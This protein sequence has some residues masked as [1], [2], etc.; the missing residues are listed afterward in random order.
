MRVLLFPHLL[1]PPLDG[2]NGER[3]R[4]VIDAEIHPARIQREIVDPVRN[5]LPQF[6][7]RE[8]VDVHFRRFAF[9]VPFPPCIF[10]VPDEFF[11]LR[12]HGDHRVAVPRGTAAQL[13]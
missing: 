11:F 2:G 3:R 4:V 7:V 10:E 13:R 6:L 5:D 8:I 1:P 9:R 12:V